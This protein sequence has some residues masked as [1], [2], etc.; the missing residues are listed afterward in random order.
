MSDH[1]TTAGSHQK[2]QTQKGEV[3]VLKD[4][5]CAI[6]SATMDT[7]MKNEAV[8]IQQEVNLELR[9]THTE[10]NAQMTYVAGDRD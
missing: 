10:F 5:M 7:K 9:K 6:N 2:G 8:E 3:C 1:A 4:D